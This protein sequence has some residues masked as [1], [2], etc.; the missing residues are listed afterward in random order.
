[1]LLSR[2]YSALFEWIAI[3]IYLNAYTRIRD[4]YLFTKQQILRDE[5]LESLSNQKKPT[6]PTLVNK[7]GDFYK[8]M[9]LEELEE[10]RPGLFHIL[11]HG[12]VNEVTNE[13]V[14]VK[15][16]EIRDSRNLEK[17]MISITSE[18]PIKKSENDSEND[19]SIS[20][21]PKLV[22]TEPD[23]DKLE[24]DNDKL[25]SETKYVFGDMPTFFPN[26]QEKSDAAFILDLLVITKRINYDEDVAPLIQVILKHFDM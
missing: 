15:S 5:I 14:G 6:E 22:K 10:S 1:M 18:N 20:S 16:I 21:T 8:I 17:S 23:K 19:S 11:K 2:E 12:N 4:R 7:I 3:G 25:K 26:W 9:Q 24:R 13:D